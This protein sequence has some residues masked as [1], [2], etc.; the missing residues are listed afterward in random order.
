MRALWPGS[1]KHSILNL[2]LNPPW[3]PK[4]HKGFR[5]FSEIENVAHFLPS[6]GLHLDLTYSRQRRLRS[7][8]GPH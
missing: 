1:I 3:T 7:L 4:F 8:C 2:L 6:H 5:G